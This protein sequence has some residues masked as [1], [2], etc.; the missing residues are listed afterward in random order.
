MI[1]F[2][3]RIRRATR[4]VLWAACLGMLVACR[5]PADPSGVDV[6][7]DAGTPN[8]QKPEVDP[9]GDKPV[10]PIAAEQPL[11]SGASE[12]RDPAPPGMLG[13]GTTGQEGSAVVPRKVPG[14]IGRRN[15]PNAL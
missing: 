5:S 1:E 12:H 2:D 10:G 11:L 9:S 14:T 7:G 4:T 13:A 8:K 3:G 6:L 15:A